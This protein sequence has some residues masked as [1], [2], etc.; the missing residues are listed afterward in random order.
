MVRDF[1]DINPSHKFFPVYAQ[2]TP[3]QRMPH[4]HLGLTKRNSGY[5]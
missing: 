5:V 4:L 3:V 2:W 1:E